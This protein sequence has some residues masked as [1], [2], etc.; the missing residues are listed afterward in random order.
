MQRRSG[1]A[2]EDNESKA[3]V[4]YLRVSTSK[5]E[6]SGL[7]LQHQASAVAAYAKQNNGEVIATYLE[8]ESGTRN[9][10]VELG[11]A[12]KECKK[13][14]AVLLVAS[15]SRLSRNAEFLLSLQRTNV[16]FEVCDMP[17]INNNRLMVGIMGL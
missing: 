11:K 8:T 9:S 1:K 14:D 3:F 17:A 6:D 4:A 16:A 15:L 5:Q 7:S 10:R 12:L 13:T 2:R